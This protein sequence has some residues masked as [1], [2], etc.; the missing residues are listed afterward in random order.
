MLIF[1][2]NFLLIKKNI[3]MKMY[4]D[5]IS[6]RHGLHTCNAMQQQQDCIDTIAYVWLNL[7]MVNI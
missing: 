5:V 2:L 6:T 3:R 1:S 7:Y 4:G